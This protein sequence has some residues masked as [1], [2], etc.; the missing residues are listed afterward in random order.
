LWIEP[1]QRAVV[2]RYR[3]KHGECGF[4]VTVKRRRRSPDGKH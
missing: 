3:V 2:R 1:E 4:S